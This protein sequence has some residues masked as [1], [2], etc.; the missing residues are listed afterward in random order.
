VIRLLVRLGLLGLAFWL[1]PKGI[2]EA[3]LPVYYRFTGTVVEGVVTGFLA[4]RVR[5]SVQPENTGVRKGR[6][7]ARPPVFLYPSKPG[8]SAH[9]EGR[10]RSAF[11][12]SFVPYELGE[13]VTV[14]FPSGHPQ[15]AYLF[16]A[17]TVAGGTLI[18]GFG[19]L[20][21]YIGLGRRL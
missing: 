19:L 20:C 16:A 18:F 8:G 3:G 6:R 4:G 10:A 9:L 2:A 15:Q 5:P 17:G 12:F 11:T 1:I 13:K 21:L 14:V 7:F